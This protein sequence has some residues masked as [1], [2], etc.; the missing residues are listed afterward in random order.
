MC[1]DSK[2]ANFMKLS[3][4]MSVLGLAPLNREPVDGGTE[5]LHGYAC[6]LLSQVLRGS[7]SG[8]IW[9]TI[10][11]HLNIIGVAVMA[12]IAA[13][14]VCESMEVPEDVIKKADQEDIVIFKSQETAYALSG[15]LYE[16]GIR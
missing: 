11:S 15:K 10:Q 14:V 16:L 2:G 6:D 9:F 5:I 1:L 12:E 13:I 4:V 8:A 3:E 7:E